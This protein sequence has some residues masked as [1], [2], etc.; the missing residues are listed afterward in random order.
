MIAMNLDTLIRILLA[1]KKII[2]YIAAGALIL[3]TAIT[4]MLPKIYTASTDLLVDTKGQDLISGQNLPTRMMTGYLGTQADIILSHN[5]AEKVIEQLHLT[6]EPILVRQLRLEN[7]SEDSRRLALFSYLGRNLSALPK[8]ES[9]VL[10]I[11]FKARNPELAARIANAF[12]RAYIQTNLEM[13]IEPAKQ[14][15]Q[16]F[17]QQLAQLRN[18]LIEKQNTLSAYQEEHSILMSDDRLD[19]E[20]AKLSELSSMLMTVQSERVNNKNRSDLIASNGRNAA[21]SLDNPQVQKLYNDLA[22]AESKLNELASNV[23]VN[24]PQY[25][26][27]LSEVESIKSQLNKALDLINSNLRSSIEL[28]QTRETQLKNELAAQKN[29]VL[30][31]SRNRNEL[32]LLKQEVDSAQSAYN[33]ALSRTSQTHLESQIA[34]TDISVLDRAEIPGAPT[35]PKLVLNVLLALFVG[36]L[37]GT[38]TALCWELWDRRIRGIYDL[39]KAIGIAVLATIPMSNDAVRIKR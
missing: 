16:W 3:A 10:T 24:H 20:N 29:R 2:I 23:G 12:A 27:T 33:T 15:T 11:S 6:E 4:I 13:R 7:K 30:Q 9:S 35:S 31:L 5:V 37:F 21:P 32:T 25:R 19:I 36:L 14:M 26:Q 1:R 34:Q 18:S 38:G 8:R 17:D 28:S 39:E 22:Q